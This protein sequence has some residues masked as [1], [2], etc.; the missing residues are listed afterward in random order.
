[1]SIQI[2]KARRMRM[3]S[4]MVVASTSTATATSMR[5]PGAMDKDMALASWC[6]VMGQ[7]TE[8]AL[9]MT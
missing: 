7:P 3:E 1:M 6:T 5:V 9:S 4:S 8:V 2:M